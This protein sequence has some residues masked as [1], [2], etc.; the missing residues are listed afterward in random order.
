M[1]TKP[2]HVKPNLY[3]YFMEGLKIIAREHGYNLLVHGSMN[4]DLDLIAIPW[5]DD[6]KPELELIQSLNEH[7]TGHRK[8]KLP[9]DTDDSRLLMGYN[10]SILPGGRSN[11]VIQMARHGEWNNYEKDLQY[12]LD[13]SVTPIAV[14][15]NS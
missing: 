4:R 11:Y 12:Y 8:G 9:E 1:N 10:H 14:I 2:T 3:T 13:I 5:V 7:L 15:T 6:P